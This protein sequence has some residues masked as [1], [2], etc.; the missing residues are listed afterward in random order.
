MRSPG[1]LMFRGFRAVTVDS[2]HLA[3]G[4]STCDRPLDWKRSPPDY[5]MSAASA[6]S[7]VSFLSRFSMN[8]SDTSRAAS[9]DT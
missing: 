8:P 5:G 7:T 4:T 2:D 1:T 3:D 6:R 9:S